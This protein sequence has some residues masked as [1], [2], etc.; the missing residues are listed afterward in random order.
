MTGWEGG[1]THPGS[2]LIEGIR[3]LFR[4]LW[5]QLGV[6]GKS[7]SSGESERNKTRMELLPRCLIL[8]YGL[9]VTQCFIQ[10]NPGVGL[11]I[12]TGVQIPSLGGAYAVPSVHHVTAYDS[13]PGIRA[14]DAVTHQPHQTYSSA[15]PLY[16]GDTFDPIQVYKDPF[17]SYQKHPETYR[18][19][20]KT[21][22]S[23]ASRFTSNIF[24]INVPVITPKGEPILQAISHPQ[25]DKTKHKHPEPVLPNLTRGTKYSSE[26]DDF[27]D[28]FEPQA[29]ADLDF[30][31]STNPLLRQGI[32]NYLQNLEFPKLRESHAPTYF[33]QDHV[34][35]TKE[36]HNFEHHTEE[37]VKNLPKTFTAPPEQFVH[38]AAIQVASLKPSHSLHQTLKL[39]PGSFLQTSEAGR[40]FK[41]N[42]NFDFLTKIEEVADKREDFHPSEGDGQPKK[43][44]NSPIEIHENI[45]ED[46]SLN[47]DKI[48]AYNIYKNQWTSTK[49]KKM[50]VDASRALQNYHKKR[51]PYIA[52]DFPN[53][54]YLDIE[55]SEPYPTIISKPERNSPLQTQFD[56]PSKFSFFTLGPDGPG[57]PFLTTFI[58][59]M[60]SLMATPI[61]PKSGSEVMYSLREIM[62]NMRN[63]QGDNRFD[64]YDWLPLFG[65]LFATALIF[66][67]L[68][69]NSLF[70]AGQQLAL[71]RSDGGRRQ[72]DD[73]IIDMAISQLEN[74]VLIMSAIRDGG[75]CSA[76][77]ACKLGDM[78]RD[79]F[80]NNDM[81]VEAMNFLVPNKYANFTES[82]TNVIRT[83]DRS[84]C[85]SVCNKCLVI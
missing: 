53:T 38:S 1:V 36:E 81:V 24:P 14:T 74:G 25:G 78:S 44:E 40:N 32:Q 83:D 19:P 79:A 64:V 35:S 50:V 41:D 57:M 31:P 58:E 23:P 4:P 29:E 61:L 34:V 9:Q 3:D 13:K 63:H 30:L 80:D 60:R 45:I 11:G 12:H 48:L 65:V 56:H 71:G 15:T 16:Y 46:A 73:N 62:H 27:D 33:P 17:Y 76:K 51:H 55:S 54:N 69:P 43:R 75:Q 67:G 82:F 28:P 49:K 10:V 84:S 37:E 39:L 59:D 66:N 22:H 18:P 8:L 47:K 42:T 7:Q 6:D 21:A 70:L 2:D 68:F 26:S 72:E 52:R 5:C 77:L 85:S 20:P